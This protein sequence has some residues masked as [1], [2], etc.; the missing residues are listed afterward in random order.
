MKA[1]NPLKRA[2]AQHEHFALNTELKRIL[3]LGA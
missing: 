2:G 1:A 3:G